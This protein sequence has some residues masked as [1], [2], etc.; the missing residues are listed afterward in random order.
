M[1]RAARI[2]MLVAALAIGFTAI[3]AAG[4]IDPGTGEVAVVVPGARVLHLVFLA[5]W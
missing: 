3:P 5:T 4:L 2:T 1:K